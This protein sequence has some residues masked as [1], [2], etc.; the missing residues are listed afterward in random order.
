MVMRRPHIRTRPRQPPLHAHISPSAKEYRLRSANQHTRN[1]TQEDFRQI[2]R[3]VTSQLKAKR[4]ELS[5]TL[6]L[7]VAKM[8][9][10]GVFSHQINEIRAKQRLKARMS[11]YMKL[12]LPKMISNERISV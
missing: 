7:E 6:P 3:N 8:N 2:K 4:D 1:I 9:S 5:Q 10:K 12:Q 11:N